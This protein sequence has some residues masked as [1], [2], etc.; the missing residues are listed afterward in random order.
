MFISDK[1]RAFIAPNFDYDAFELPESASLVFRLNQHANAR[2]LPPESD[3][4][5]AIKATDVVVLEAVTTTGDDRWLRNIASGDFKEYQAFRQRVQGSDAQFGGWLSTM[6]GAIYGSRTPAINVDAKLSDSFTRK[7]QSI[8]KQILRNIERATTNDDILVVQDKLALS[9][10]MIKA[11]DQHILQ[12]LAPAL[13]NLAM[14][15]KRVG[16]K[17]NSGPLHVTLFY[18]SMHRS[19]HDALLQKSALCPS[20]G[21]SSQ[22]H[23]ENETGNIAETLYAQRLRNISWSEQ[24][25]YQYF[26]QNNITAGLVSYGHVPKG[27]ST[28][29]LR[30]I[31]QKLIDGLDYTESHNLLERL[32]KHAGPY[33]PYILE[34]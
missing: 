17:K 10:D 2:D 12:R 16:Q 33:E 25:V 1:E 24:S 27:L 18:G 34:S 29:Q 19:L 3:L 4:R 13:G 11:R 26:A 15:D 28:T 20:D 5:D 8:T 6:M 31:T 21:F 22:L 23:P 7:Y 32:R 9:M 14:T 30:R